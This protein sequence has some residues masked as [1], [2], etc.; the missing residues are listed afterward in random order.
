MFPCISLSERIRILTTAL[1]RVPRLSE[2]LTA[3][4]A[5]DAYGFT[6]RQVHYFAED[7][8]LP[9]VKLDGRRRYAPPIAVD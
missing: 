7:G 5:A 3:R 9:T 6:V 4:E 1:D 2:W 8:R